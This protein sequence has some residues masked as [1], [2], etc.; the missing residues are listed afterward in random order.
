MSNLSRVIK[1]YG[2]S[3]RRTLTPVVSKFNLYSICF[4]CKSNLYEHAQTRTRVIVVFQ[5]F[6][7]KY[8]LFLEKKTV[9]Y[10]Q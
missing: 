7:I 10:K 3:L 4:P 2:R 1:L 6:V 8:I 9:C 5:L